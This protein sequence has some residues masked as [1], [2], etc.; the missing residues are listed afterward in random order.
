LFSKQKEVSLFHQSGRMLHALDR[1]EG[2]SRTVYTQ[3]D[4][5]AVTQSNFFRWTLG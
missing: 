1:T 4:Y 5:T 2:P 3:R